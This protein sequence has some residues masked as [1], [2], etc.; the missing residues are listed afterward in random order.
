MDCSWH[1]HIAI[2]IA[3]TPIIIISLNFKIHKAILLANLYQLAR[4]LAE[5]TGQSIWYVAKFQGSQVAS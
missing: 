5:E 4:L 2:A 3:S 1:H